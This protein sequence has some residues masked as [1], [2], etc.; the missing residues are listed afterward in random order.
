MSGLLKGDDA[1]SQIDERLVVVGLSLPPDEECSKAVVPGVGSFDD[2]ATSAVATLAAAVLFPAAPDM[3]GDA[4]G[5]EHHSD[6]RVVVAL[7]QAKVPRSA[8]SSRS[9]YADL[10]EHVG[11]HPLVMSIGSGDFNRERY[12]A[13]IGEHV[14]F[15]SEFSP[16]RGILPRLRPPLGALTI[17]PSSEAHSQSIP[18][19][20]S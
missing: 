7:V 8:R 2:P 11:N 4:P 9:A 6:V 15:Y 17:A 13:T 14:P 16:V 20:L 1:R 19:K 12:T 5:A 3:G 10:V 18:T